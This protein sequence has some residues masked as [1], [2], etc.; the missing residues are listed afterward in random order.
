MCNFLLLSQRRGAVAVAAAVAAA[1]LIA[2]FGCKVYELNRS[3][4]FALDAT[5]VWNFINIKVDLV[6]VQ[7]HDKIVK[8]RENTLENIDKVFLASLLE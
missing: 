1:V 2:V 8:N 3:N 4:Q 5:I 7:K 6:F